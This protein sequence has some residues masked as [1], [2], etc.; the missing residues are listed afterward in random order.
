MVVL[1]IGIRSASE[2]GS[3]LLRGEER[4]APVNPR[5]LRRV[6]VT[7]GAAFVV[8]F[9]FWVAMESGLVESMVGWV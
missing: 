9:L 4:G 7:T 6:C 8:T 1:P 5:L 3:E 2:E